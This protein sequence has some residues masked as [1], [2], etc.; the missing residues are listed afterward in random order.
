MYITMVEKKKQKAHAQ[1]NTKDKNIQQG[2]ET[3][4]YLKIGAFNDLEHLSSSS[5]DVILITCI[6]GYSL[7][8]FFHHF[9]HSFSIEPF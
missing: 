3:I 1:K 4:Y 6:A 9:N 2:L 5:M 7:A 8:D